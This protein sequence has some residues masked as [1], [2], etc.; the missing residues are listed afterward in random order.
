MVRA[1]VLDA[2]RTPFGRFRGGLSRIRVDDLAALPIS[3]LLRRHGQNGSGRLDPTQIDDVVLGNANGAGEDNRNVGR[4]AALLAG[5]P[6][7]VPGVTVNRLCGSGGEALIQAS[8]AVATG[9]ADL[10]IAGGVEGMS[11]APFVLPTP[12]T[13]HP[14]RMELVSTAYGWH[15]INP[16]MPN[17]WTVPI[18]YAAEQVT[19]AHG[20][21]RKQL[22]DYA[23]RSHR[24]AS[25]AWDAG[26][27][28]GF[29][30]P[31][32]LPDGTMLRRDESVRADTSAAKLG[33]LPSAFSGTGPVTAGNS[34][35]RSDGAV[36]A[37]IGSERAAAQLELRP[38]GEILGSARAAGRP[39]DV[40]EAPGLAIR[41]LLDRFDIR[42]SE[43]DLWEINETFAAVVLGVLRG[44]PGVDAERVNV[45]GG[46]LAYGHPLGASLLRVIVDLC[47]A[48]TARGGGLGVAVASISVGQAVAVAVR[49]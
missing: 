19:I 24:R 39:Q 15:L 34:A 17:E 30:F 28:N 7:S 1:L 13:G 16:R 46:A 29:V 42:Q 38:I 27:H 40:V 4:M 37:L 14:D 44:L 49:A 45:H 26:V 41:K 31:V 5:L 6:V 23:L 18:G 48:L 33:E 21:T 9:D 25:A 22:D 47:R 32:H 12:E 20:L 35:P 11:R 43:V 8:R 2:A 36:A 3:A 10:I